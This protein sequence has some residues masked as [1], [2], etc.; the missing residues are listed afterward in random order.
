M[1]MAFISVLLIIFNTDK[2]YFNSKMADGDCDSDFHFSKRKQHVTLRK[3]HKLDD[4]FIQFDRLSSSNLFYEIV[5]V[6]FSFCS[7]KVNFQMDVI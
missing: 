4:S 1:Q 6:M 7:F 5:L 2:T 3:R